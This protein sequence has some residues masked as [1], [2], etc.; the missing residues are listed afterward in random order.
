[1][2]V[3]HPGPGD[4]LV[5]AHQR[6]RRPRSWRR[7]ASSGATPTAPANEPSP[8]SRPSATTSPS[9][10]PPNTRGSTFQDSNAPGCGLMP[11]GAGQLSNGGGGQA[12]AQVPPPRSRPGW[13]S[14]PGAVTR[15]RSGR[16]AGVAGREDVRTPARP[17]LALSASSGPPWGC[18]S[19]RPSGHLVS[20]C[21]ASG[22]SRCPDGQA[23][24]VRG[25]AAALSAPRWTWS[26]S[27]WR[28]APVGRSGSTCRRGP[29]AAWS[30][31]WIGPD[32]RRW[33]GGGRGWLA[34]GLTMAPGPPLGRCPGGG[35][36]LAPAGR[37]GCWSRARVPTGWRGSPGWSRR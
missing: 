23:C 14:A 20:R 8:S 33:C 10:P 31:A 37:Q 28:A 13:P 4:R 29:R 2:A 34:R 26:G 12:A 18:P 36:A 5:P 19:N 11:G 1:M 6:L 35:A 17:I 16:P 7:P 32:G 21:P 27:G 30:P 22:A 25:A 15:A 24:G 3:G 9:N